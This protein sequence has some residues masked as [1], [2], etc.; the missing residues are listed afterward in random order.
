MADFTSKEL[1]EYIE[2]R[3]KENVIDSATDFVAECIKYGIKSNAQTI[4]IYTEKEI[5]LIISDSEKGTDEII[6]VICKEYN[7]YE[8]DCSKLL[9]SI[10][11][12]TKLKDVVELGKN[13][14]ELY[15]SWNKYKNT[16]TPEAAASV[17]VGVF[18][19]CSTIVGMTDLGIIGN[20]IS[21]QLELGAYL[22]EKG[23]ELTL[24]YNKRFEE[25]DAIL[26]ELDEMDKDS[27][28][29]DMQDKV[30]AAL[31]KGQ[32]IYEI[33]LQKKFYSALYSRY[34]WIYDGIDT[35][36]TRKIKEINSEFNKMSFDS[37]VDKYSKLMEYGE[38]TD[39]LSGTGK[40]KKVGKV[41]DGFGG[42]KTAQDNKDPLVID[43]NKNGK[44]TNSQKEG[45]HFDFDG[46]GFAEKT[47]WIESGDGL[48]VRDINHNG[49]I[50]DGSELFGDKTIMSNGKTASNGFEALA[51]LDSNKDGI[52]DE[53]DAAF[54]EIKVWIDKN[55]NGITDE[56]ELFTLKDLDITSI[57]L[58]YTSK[59]FRDNDSTVTGISIVNKGDGST[60]TIGNL[61]F[62]IDTTDTISKKNIK[63]PD[64][65]KNKMPQLY[66]S[67]NILSLQEA[68][69][70]DN[71]LLV[72]VDKFINT[73]DMVQKN[74]LMD[75]ILLRW[76]G[77]ENIVSGSRGGNIDATKLAVIEKFYGTSFVGV[78]GS[79]PNQ[80]AS[81]ILNNL[82]NDI[83]KSFKTKLL[84]Q[85]D[86]VQI[87]E[88]TKINTKRSNGN[89]RINYSAVIE[90][91][92][93]LTGLGYA[94]E[95]IIFGYYVNYI[96]NSDLTKD[97][98]DEKQL[99]Q[100]IRKSQYSNLYIEMLE[101]KNEY[102]GN[103]EDNVISASDGNDRI[104]GG[105]GNDI[106]YGG[107]GNDSIYGGSGNDTLH[108]GY[109][110]D[111][112]YFEL[113][114]GEDTI[115]E[116]G[117]YVNVDR[118]VFGKGISP[119]N[120]S[121]ERIGNDLVIKYSEVD[122]VTVKNAY[123]YKKY[124]GYGYYFVEKIEF[125]D[126][127]V[128]NKDKLIELISIK[129]GTAGNDVLTGYEGTDVYNR[130]ETFYAGAG[131]DIINANDGNDLVYA[132]SEN[133]TVNGG[134][135]D[136]TIYGGAGDDILNGEGGNDKLYGGVGNDT[137][138]GGYGDD[139]YY[140][141]LGDGEDTIYEDG[142]YVNVDR[143]VFGKGINPSD[144]AIERVGNDI[145]IRYSAADRITIKNAYGYKRYCG[146][147]YYFVENIEFSDGTVWNKDKLIE[148][149]SIKNGT[150]GND[151]LTG[152]EGTDVY[153]INETFYG[154]AGNDTI[155]GGD[156][157]DTYIFGRGDGIDT[158]VDNSGS[159][160]LSFEENISIED[161]MMTK[162]GNNLE[163]SISDT[164]DKIIL[165]DYFI[166]SSYQ[167]FTAEFADGSSLSQN[168]F[169]SIING[170]YVYESALKQSELL[171]QSMA[172]TSDDGN[173]SEMVNITTQ[174]NNMT[175]TQLFVSNQ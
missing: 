59:N 108:G 132:G 111:T 37:F 54:N 146:Y 122:K 149:I 145:I 99:K 135:G 81:V 120:I 25:I 51:D 5:M 79:N 28:D 130:N 141:E 102:F 26:E 76:T 153:N 56:G 106:I 126:G 159:N 152:Y 62:N 112:Y 136:D 67:G 93:K 15:K 92:D 78:N 73:K 147:G 161:L 23:T 94:D 133:D 47:S 48:L 171:V 95:S 140:F 148:L 39:G 158:I 118:I 77:C 33:A 34:G 105:A 85:T 143:I 156:G 80:S 36:E 50:D 172:S 163:V 31:T 139:T 110:N 71:E 173:V 41:N 66:A 8:E 12:A 96:K 175:D 113:G 11:V 160:I 88:L 2:E 100:Y 174:D 65:I 154:G 10:D 14:N 29:T 84:L 169:S 32:S 165:N 4:G 58:N 52:I 142:E 123:G 72:L 144:V 164:T 68:M 63:I 21:E 70:V 60:Y 61:N 82:Y 109:G 155:Y 170:T 150:A 115:Y 57:L 46:E 137:L 75:K 30:N 7:I 38:K 104:Y 162:N 16:S 157:N 35:E 91:F 17:M 42:A 87:I 119:E 168:D 98:Y 49:I 9:T 18:S 24:E 55:N 3:V 125:S 128:W 97:I 107:T 83:N 74:T 134:D 127:T 86:L 1:N 53:K 166:N 45:T 44:Y 27:L 89:K 151:V 6:Q 22:L 64:E 116:D 117:E 69:T 138:N 13:I 101:Y 40:D 20:I 43:L 121:L 90:Y 114:D 129:T 167:N 19:A 131:D 124:C 103:N